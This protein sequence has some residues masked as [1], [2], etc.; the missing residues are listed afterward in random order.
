MVSVIDSGVSGRVWVLVTENLMLGSNPVI[1]KH[2]TQGGVEILPVASC[3]WNRDKLWPDEPLSLD[4]DF[5][6]YLTIL[7]NI[8]T[9]FFLESMA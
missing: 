1:D 7:N 3:F 6:F 8:T 5:T 4:A 2:S 9:N